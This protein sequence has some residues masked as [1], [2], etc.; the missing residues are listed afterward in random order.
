MLESIYAPNA[1]VHMLSGKAITRAVRGDFIV[2]KDQD[3]DEA[4]TLYE[5]LMAKEIS[6][7]EVCS[8]NVLERIKDNLKN[9]SESVKKFSRTSALTCTSCTNSSGY[10]RHASLHGSFRPQLIHQAC[11]ALF[12]ADVEPQDSTS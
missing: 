6:A 2:T 8:S 5:K 12:A 7:E 9:H 1:V 11:H 4:L 10:P 3:V